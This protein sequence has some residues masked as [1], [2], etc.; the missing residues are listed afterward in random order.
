MTPQKILV[1]Q[2]A[3]LGD[4]VL[5][6][7]VIEKLAK[8][9]PTSHIDF[10]L[11]KGN[12]SLLG[13]NPHLRKVLVW[14][15]T[16]LKTRNLLHMI[17]EVRKEK[18]DLVVNLQRF[19]SSGLIT[20]LSGA[21]RT[22]GFSS[23]P[24]SFLFSDSK[25]HLVTWKT[26]EPFLHEVERNQSLISD[27]T[28]QRSERPALYPS[29][30]DVQIA[31]Q[32]AAGSEFVTISPSSVWF[33]KQVPEKIWVDLINQLSFRVLL[34]GGPGD[35]ELCE[36][37]AKACGE[38]Q[39]VVLAGKLTLLQSAALMKK[40]VMNYTNDSAPLHLASS[41]NAPVTAVYCS[42][43][44]E[45]G[46]G[47]LNDVSHIVQVREKPPCLSCGLHGKKSCPLGHFECSRI[48]VADLLNALKSR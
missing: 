31:D 3:F 17:S 18:Y 44:P 43:I 7:A 27:I 2:P 14:D 6:T 22:V 15:K 33:T 5:A 8:F 30:A 40:A 11:R 26:G 37:I 25:P 47:P 4:V 32:Y 48:E 23:N 21:K 41:M 12:E 34:L 46:F 35:R 45:F 29:N 28:D 13:N 24:L 1:I 20:A 42:T 39:V 10:L 19:F 36:R 16:Q 9:F 38:K